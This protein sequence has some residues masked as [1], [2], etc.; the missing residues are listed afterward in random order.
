MHRLWF[1]LWTLF[2]LILN[3]V[4]PLG[5]SAAPAVS[6]TDVALT[7]ANLL[8]AWFAPLPVS[9]ETEHE[10][11]PAWFASGPKHVSRQPT[12]HET[13]DTGDNVLPLWFSTPLPTNDRSPQ[14][15]HHTIHDITV[16]GPDGPINNCDVVTFTV[17]AANDAFTTTGVII[18]STM[19]AGFTPTQIVF[20]VGTVGPNQV[21]TRY[22]VFSATC[23]AVSG[24]N[25]VT[26]TQNGVPPIVKYTDFVVNPGAI[27]VRKD[28]AVIPAA[29]G[30]VVTWT[31]YVENTGY[32][33]VS[34]IRVTDTLGGGL[35]YVSGIT[36]AYF[37]SIPV[38]GVVTFPLAAR[39]VGC[40]GSGERRHSH[41]GLQW[42]AG[43]LPAWLRGG[44]PG[45]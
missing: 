41:L 38:G 15:D 4:A 6:A 43:R 19:P 30:E 20:P 27:T 17:V 7:G 45:G 9:Q 34:N 40:S 13:R 21:I 39:V 26:L 2:S 18:T 5:A 16:I 37:L 22:A 36:S 24:Q 3:L 12:E 28:P 14:A 23:D 11:L 25:V 29:P 1:S 35:Q 44:G 33:T 31:V 10:V 8:P 42:P 32:G